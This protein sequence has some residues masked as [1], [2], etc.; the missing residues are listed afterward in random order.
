MGCVMSRKVPTSS[1]GSQTSSCGRNR[2]STSSTT[3]HS[4]ITSVSE[5]YSMGAT[6]LPNSSPALSQGSTRLIKPERAY[7]PM[8]S[9]SRRHEREDKSYSGAF[10]GINS[11]FKSKKVLNSMSD[12]PLTDT[13]NSTTSTS[14]TTFFK[15]KKQKSKKPKKPSSSPQAPTESKLEIVRN[16]LTLYLH[17]TSSA[18][19]LI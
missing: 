13:N 9:S 17:P 6:T 8:D 3:S 12:I 7:S 14:A 19:N 1:T 10:E 16:R 11:L 4:S 5:C 18:N 2:Y 15:Q